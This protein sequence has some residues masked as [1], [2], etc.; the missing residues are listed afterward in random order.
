[1]E[2][3][4]SLIDGI[5]LVETSHWKCIDI[6]DRHGICVH[7]SLKTP[8]GAA[9]LDTNLAGSHGERHQVWGPSHLFQY[10]HLVNTRPMSP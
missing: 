2:K 3:A 10:P 1:M 9:G 4:N 6:G 7:W 8:S 5:L